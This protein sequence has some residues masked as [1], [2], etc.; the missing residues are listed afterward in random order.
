[1][2]TAVLRSMTPDGSP[3]A[4]SP[5]VP[6]DRGERPVVGQGLHRMDQCHQGPPAFSWP[7]AAAPADRSRLLRPPGQR[8]PRGPGR[9]GP[10]PWRD[11]LLLLALLV[12]RPPPSAAAVGRGDRLR[13]A[14][15]SLLYRL[16]QP[17]VVGN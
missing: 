16:G 9:P 10:A 14:R 7:R 8:D 4:L 5:T 17:D 13:N 2:V 11:R 3:G 15:F 1:M 12:C 6:P